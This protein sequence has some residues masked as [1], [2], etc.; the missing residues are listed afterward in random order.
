MK[1]RSRIFLI[2]LILLACVGMKTTD[3]ELNRW[4]YDNKRAP[5]SLRIQGDEA[6]ALSYMGE[7]KVL[8][9]SVKNA[10]RLNKQPVGWGER[11]PGDGTVI[12]VNCTFG[13]DVVLIDTRLSVG[14]GPASCTIT[15]ISLPASVP[16]MRNLVVDMGMGTIDPG[17][18]QGVDYFKTYFSVTTKNCPTCQR[19]S[20][21][22][23]YTYDI[24]F[25]PLHYHN[26]GSIP[27]SNDGITT[28]PPGG[29]DPNDH[30]VYS[31]S[32]PAKGEVIGQGND[33]GGSYFIWKAYTETPLLG[34]PYSRNGLGILLI[35]A[36][37]LDGKGK[38]VC[39]Q[40][41]KVRVDCCLKNPALRPVEIWWEGVNC[42]CTPFMFYPDAAVCGAI[43]KAPTT[44]AMGGFYGLI[45]YACVS[46]QQP[47]YS[48]PEIKG[49]CLPIEW[50]L[51]GPI[52]FF[53]PKDKNNLTL[54]I[55]CLPFGCN[56]TA[57]IALT[58]RCGN[59]Y[60]IQVQ[61]CC[62]T[63]DPLTLNY[64][65]LQM[66]CGGQQQF[67][68]SKGCPPYVY[69]CN[70]GIIDQ[71]GNYT[72]PSSNGDCAN[73][74]TVTVTDCCGNSASCQIAVNCYSGPSVAITYSSCSPCYGGCLCLDAGGC[75]QG[76]VYCGDWKVW[77]Y[78]CDGTF[79]SECST[80]NGCSGYQNPP[81]N[82]QTQGWHV[83][84]Q[85][86]PNS[87]CEECFTAQ[88]GGSN[89]CNTAVDSRTSG[90]KSGGCCPI[91]PYTGLP[92]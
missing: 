62:A 39:S 90:M 71:G 28:V 35:N 86:S 43:C 78:K 61:S 63:C 85:C 69:S 60:S 67:Q 68:G 38:T 5:V 9:W 37:I 19:I 87:T 45:E 1:W 88:C 76:I 73:N 81:C 23:T 65:S 4:R 21:S 59:S 64:T 42:N 27:Y 15:F 83:S 46:P 55:K 70:T 92:F 56:D 84:D 77:T 80:S 12:S 33:A 44:M 58:D 50:T 41:Q 25:E 53:H 89:P 75:N 79:I 32:P 49:S 8:L 29:D 47:F 74:D 52:A 91:N 3:E 11:R 22:M 18:V 40:Q 13:L 26:D 66:S 34:L 17:E 51:S 48:I 2:L 54:F 82:G 6:L 31:L 72:A 24:P 10:M 16:P 57:G 30:L 36:E 14:V 20:M 7:A